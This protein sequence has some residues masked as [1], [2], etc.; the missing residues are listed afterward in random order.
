M[1]CRLLCAHTIQHGLMFFL[2]LL[3]V[4]LMPLLDLTGTTPVVQAQPNT[5]GR[6]DYYPLQLGNRWEYRV[7]VGGE[8]KGKGSFVVAAIETI[9]LVPLARVEAQINGRIVATEH[10]RVTKDG[11]YRYRHNGAEVKVPVLVLRYPVKAGDSWEYETEV[12]QEKGKAKV[13]TRFEDVE[14]PLGKFKALVTEID[15]ESNGQ[16]LRTSIWFAENVGIVKQ[17][18]AQGLLEFTMELEKFTKTKPKP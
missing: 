7:K 6:Q 2:M 13:T 17:T 1:S 5:E 10:L 4:I 8:V 15:G 3:S 12:G 16:T 18:F 14:V 11:V 9:N